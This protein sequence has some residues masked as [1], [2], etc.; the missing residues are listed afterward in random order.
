MMMMSSMTSEGGLKVSPL[1]SFVNEM[2][3]F[4]ITKKI[5]KDIIIK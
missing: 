2:T 5:N 3:L 1:Y 4:M